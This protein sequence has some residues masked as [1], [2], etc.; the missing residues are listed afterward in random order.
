MTDRLISVNR[1][2]QAYQ[3]LDERN[4]YRRVFDEL[5]DQQP[6]VDPKAC[7]KWMRYDMIEMTLKGQAEALRQAG[8]LSGADVLDDMAGFFSGVSDLIV[9]D[10]DEL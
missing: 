7:G 3:F 6:S 1:L 2:K 8:N 4:Y 10:N 9:E 5:I